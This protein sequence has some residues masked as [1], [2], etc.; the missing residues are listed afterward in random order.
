MRPS[1][2]ILL[3]ED[4]PSML[5]GM[6]DLLQTFDVGFDTQII[7]A[8]D[9]KEGLRA[10]ASVIPDLIISDVMMP[11]VDGYEFL[12]AVRRNP[13]W[14]HIPFI[15]LTA[16][17]E[18]EDIH[19]GKVS[20]ADLYIT[21]PFRTKQFLELIESQ[22]NKARTLNATRQ[23][24]VDSLKK[25]ILQILNHEFRTPLTYVTAY[26]E[27][28]A[29]SMDRM[30]EDQD[31]QEYLHGIQAGC[32]R[33]TRL[34]E[35]LILVIEL[36]TGEAAV[37]HERNI[38]P[39]HHLADLLQET[40]QQ[41]EEQHEL[42][43]I[44][45][46]LAVD[47]H[48]PPVLGDP[49]RLP[50]V[51]R[52]LLDNAVKFTHNHQHTDGRIQITLLAAGDEVRIVFQDE[53]IGFPPHLK[54][55]IFDLFYQY[56]RDT[57]EQQGAGIGL[58]IVQGLVELHQGS[59][60]VE[61]HEG[62]GTIFT[63]RLPVLNEKTGRPVRSLI[64]VAARQEATILVV[65]D[66]QFLLTGLKELLEVSSDRYQLNVL[67]AL[68][69]RLGLEVLARHQPDLIISD[70]MMPE[71]DGYAFLHQVRQ[72]PEWLQI[73]VIF[74]TAKGDPK[75][76]HRGLRSGVEQY[77][78]KPYDSDELLELVEAQ[79]DRHFQVQKAITRSFNSLKRSVLSLITPDFR[80]PLTAVAKYSEKLA[81]AVG[82]AETDR[83]LKESLVGI[84][85]GSLRLTRL[86]E[87]FIFLAELRTG[88]A[89]AAF[90]LRAHPTARA[91]FL[92]QEVARECSQDLNARGIEIQCADSTALP[93][94]LVDDAT[95]LDS[96]RRLIEYSAEHC[97]SDQGHRI[98]LAAAHV[99]DEVR[100]S[101][102]CTSPLSPAQA[103]EVSMLLTDADTGMLASAVE[104]PS[105]FIARGYAK[106]H[107]GYIRLEHDET[108]GHTFTLC[109]PI[110]STETANTAE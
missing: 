14:V 77:I 103:A 9:G 89:R 21:K 106:L 17:G 12:K 102:H 65:E 92:L 101:I 66:E 54:D 22:L 57:L 24:D 84:Q 7:T 26:Y 70:I 75:D 94:V 34:I 23:R 41:Y 69:G 61:S 40:V 87:D 30:G 15:F 31:F 96:C 108:S 104:A 50:T 38:Q 105:L 46:H 42:Y 45:I 64:K 1:A 47:E 19:A 82:H 25:S 109:L 33:L 27:M 59:V 97:E 107:D 90:D 85:S 74:L 62:V 67:T 78:A 44:H 28:L 93:A 11:H 71:M 35:D 32:I 39:I 4:D 81:S 95:L 43:N 60:E 72:N 6:C 5:D 56:N 98:T 79:L 110:L 37:V 80:L 83:E 20:G 16:K 58:A 88:E 86:V 13:A 63:M 51:F 49:K 2:T 52:H 48:L 53:G 99:N 55:K 8:T 29:D 68:N 76:V 36:R 18:Q 100:F 73:P 10:V 3:V 91:G